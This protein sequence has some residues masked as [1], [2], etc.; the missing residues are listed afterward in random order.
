MPG[1]GPHS[2]SL[3]PLPIPRVPCN[4]MDGEKVG[5]VA[6]QRKIWVLLPKP[7]S[8]GVEQ[9]EMWLSAAWHRGMGRS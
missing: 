7:G 8:L 2:P 6:P 3:G 4:Y 5:E 1:D 9:G